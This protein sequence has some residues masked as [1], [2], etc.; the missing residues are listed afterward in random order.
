MKINGKDYGLYLTT[1]AW[2]DIA[3][4]TETGNFAQVGDLMQGKDQMKNVVKILAILSKGYADYMEV[5][6]GKERPAEL[7]EKF[8]SAISPYVLAEQGV[9][10]EITGALQSGTA[11]EVEEEPVKGKNAEGAATA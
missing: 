3:A 8:L 5:V 11:R 1:Q 6:E 10:E 4:L 7:T 9:M 2:S